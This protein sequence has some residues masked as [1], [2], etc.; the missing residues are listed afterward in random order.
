LTDPL[1]EIRSSRRYRGVFS[2][3]T[4]L[5]MILN[6]SATTNPTGDLAITNNFPSCCR[7]RDV[8]G[9]MGDSFQLL[10]VFLPCLSSLAPHLSNPDDLESL[11]CI[12]RQLVLMLDQLARNAQFK[13]SI[14]KNSNRRSRLLSL[15]PWLPVIF[16]SLRLA[17]VG[18][19][20]GPKPLLAPHRNRYHRRS[21]SPPPLLEEQRRRT[22]PNSGTRLVALDT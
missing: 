3:R 18:T 15:L 20:M 16:T 14:P 1:D 21:V 17:Q 10:P 4:Y 5:S 9:K 19:G 13:V 8:E 12:R 11:W 6:F 22:R 2:F 7:R